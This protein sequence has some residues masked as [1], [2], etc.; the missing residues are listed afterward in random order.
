MRL[1]NVGDVIMT[2]E[3]YDDLVMELDELRAKREA[4]RLYQRAYMKPYMK[5]RRANAL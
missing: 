1:I 3:E 4:K 2:K 5:R